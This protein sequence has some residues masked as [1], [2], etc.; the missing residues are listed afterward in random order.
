[1]STGECMQQ[2]TLLDQSAEQYVRLVLALGQHDPDYVDAYYGPETWQREAMEEG[3]SLATLHERAVELLRALEGVS[4]AT[5]DG[6][7]LLRLRYLT[8]QISAA[9]ARVQM[10]QGMRY[11][12]D[13]EALALYDALPPSFSEAHFAALV[14]DVGKL[15]PGD[16]EVHT[17]FD[18]FKRQFIVPLEKLDRVF[19]AA[20]NEGRRR[21]ASHIALPSGEQFTVEYVNNKAWS[22]YNWYKGNATSLIQVNVDYPITIDRAIDLACHEGYPGHHVY[23]SL[24]ELNLA[25]GLGWKEF[26]V[27]ALFSPQS[28]VAEGT[29]NFG[30]DI[31]FPGTER[32]EFEREVLFPLA[33][34]NPEGAGH[35]YEVHSLV[36]R[37]AYAGNEAAR[38]YLDGALSR[39]ETASWLVRYALMSPD[40]AEQ[41]TRFFDKYRSY[42]INYNLGQDL[43]QQA[44][45]QSGGTPGN[46]ERR[47]ELFAQLLS[48]PRIPSTLA[49][50]SSGR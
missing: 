35:Y 38:R 11:A 47:W 45:E 2:S 32:V 23:N 16:G 37:L 15:I 20:I 13:D 18:S 43:V 14:G 48:S 39:D 1:M 49:V 8:R 25:R 42:V 30:I 50:T 3:A 7:Q 4:G 6:M 17:R 10:L 36:Q 41:R 9:I 28:L 27:Y 21:T 40:R 12:F 22:G 19:A 31:A 26:T 34:I 24:L 33:G 5:L 46:P 44:I 29:A